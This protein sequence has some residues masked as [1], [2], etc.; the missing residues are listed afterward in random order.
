[1]FSMFDATV[2]ITAKPERLNATEIFG[3]LQSAG[4]GSRRPTQLE[5]KDVAQVLRRFWQSHPQVRLENGMDVLTGLG[6]VLPVQQRGGKNNGWLKPP[7][8]TKL[9]S[10]SEA[11]L[12]NLR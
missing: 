3:L 1:M 8:T 12:A 10:R 6:E 7:E 11:A 5:L 2:E 9:T 4:D